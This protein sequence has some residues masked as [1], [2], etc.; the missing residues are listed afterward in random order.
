MAAQALLVYRPN[1]VL[2]Q[3][4]LLALYLIVLPVLILIH[5]GI[6]RFCLIFFP[7]IRLILNDLWDGIFAR[8]GS[9]RHADNDFSES[10]TGTTSVDVRLLARKEQLMKNLAVILIVKNP[11]LLSHRDDRSLSNQ[12]T[13]TGTALRG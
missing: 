4:L 7:K 2:L 9:S 3:C 13:Y 5:C 6:G 8:L 12:F 10:E 11:R 1:F